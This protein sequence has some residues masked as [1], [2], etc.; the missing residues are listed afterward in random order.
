MGQQGQK[1]HY[2]QNQWPKRD[3]LIPGKKN[4]LNNPLVNPEKVF[5]PS[6]HIRL[7]PMKNFITAMDKNAQ[8]LCI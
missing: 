8:D 3:S 1:K 6:L 4:V 5:L 2:I 7:G